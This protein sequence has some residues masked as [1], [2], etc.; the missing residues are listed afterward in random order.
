MPDWSYH[1][2][3]QRLLFKLPGHIS[4]EMI[5][6]S[7]SSIASLPGGN[8]FIRFLGQMETSLHNEVKIND[9]RFS[10]PIGLSGKVD[11]NL[12]GTKAYVN[13]GFS[14]I[15]IGPIT[16]NPKVS[17]KSYYDKGKETIVFPSEEETLDLD[18]TIKKFKQYSNLPLQKI[19]RM[20]GKPKELVELVTALKPYGDLFVLDFSNQISLE[21]VTLIKKLINDKHV[22]LSVTPEQLSELLTSFTHYLKETE[23]DGVVLDGDRAK[24]PLTDLLSSLKMLRGELGDKIPIITSGGINEPKD[25]ISLLDEG[26]TLLLLSSGYITSGPGLPKRINELVYFR[27]TDVKQSFSPGWIWYWLFGFSIF[28]GGI[29]ALLFS[30]TRVILPYDEAFLGITRAELLNFNENVLYFMA[31]DRTTLSGT[32]ISGG[33]LYMQLAKH[34]IKSGVYWCRKAVNIAGILGFLG[35]LLFIGYGYFDWLHGIFWLILLPFFIAGFL[36]TKDAIDKPKSHNDSNHF[37][38]KLSLYGQLAF[39]ILGFSF[40]IGGIVISYIGATFVFVKTD[41]GYLCMPPDMIEQFNDELIS[42]I[43]HDRAGFGSA[44]LSVGLLVLMISLWGFREGE[45]WVWWS[46]LIGGIPAFLSGLITHFVIGYTTLIH[47]LPAYIA[48]IIYIFGLILSYPFLMKKKI[49]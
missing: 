39:I 43:A 26:A 38:W 10:S 1:T 9:L 28:I 42:V 44:L 4:R 37:P 24:E 46:M 14:F 34:G 25:A 2:M 15:E 3:F 49:S 41:I 47:L 18:K 31:H 40:V 17:K 33:I 19:I 35:I 20:K 6:K 8:S 30:M 12:T 36:K 27:K 21:H 22:F 29:V 5:H 16:L 13:L 11:P 23:L 32:M 48:C 7:M 45:K